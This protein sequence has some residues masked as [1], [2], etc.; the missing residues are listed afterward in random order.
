MAVDSI[1]MNI[2]FVVLMFLQ[3]STAMVVVA[4]FEEI[5]AIRFVDNNRLKPSRQIKRLFDA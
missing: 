4:V 1:P 5:G 3:S 2:W